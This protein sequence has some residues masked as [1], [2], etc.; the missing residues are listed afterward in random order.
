MIS[1]D[2]VVG[3]NAEC[4]RTILVFPVLIHVGQKA[5]LLEGLENLGDV[6]IFTT[7]ITE[8]AATL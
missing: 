2:I 1:H 6:G 3:W 8:P 4:F 7:S 5:G